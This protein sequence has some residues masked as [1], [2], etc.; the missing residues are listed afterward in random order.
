MDNLSFRLS[1]QAFLYRGRRFVDL[2]YYPHHQL[3]QL[4]YPSLMNSTVPI[5]KSKKKR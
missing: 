4:F 3:S 5:L 1:T 2:R